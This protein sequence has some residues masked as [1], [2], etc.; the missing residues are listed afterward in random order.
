M[1]FPEKEGGYGLAIGQ[2]VQTS[3]FGLFASYRK[4][5]IP[6]FRCNRISAVLT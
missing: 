6:I 1:M 5:E 4:S 2:L 3:A